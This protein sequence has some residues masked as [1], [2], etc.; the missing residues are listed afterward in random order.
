MSEPYD[1]LMGA[2]PALD[3]GGPVLGE[4]FVVIDGEDGIEVT[5]P[6]GPEAWHIE[7]APGDDPMIVVAEVVTRVLGAPSLLHSTSWRRAK[8]A[9][10]LTFVAVVERAQVDGMAR[11]AVHRVELARGEA[12]TAPKGIAGDEVLEHALRHL[13][14]LSQD[15][16]VVRGI[17][18]DRWLAHLDSYTPEPFRTLP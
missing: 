18:D 1:A 13:A 14:W 8:G 3:V 9:V 16:D 12:T 7:V 5:G 2:A 11:R 15:D 10:T 17:L 6:C 4:V